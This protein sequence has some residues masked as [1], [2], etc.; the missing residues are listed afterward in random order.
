LKITFK[1]KIQNGLDTISGPV[2]DV[3]SEII[4]E[5]DSM[6]AYH[7]TPTVGAMLEARRYFA[8]DNVK[9][10][11]NRYSDSRFTGSPYYW[12]RYSRVSTPESYAGGTVVR[13]P[14]CN[15][16]APDGKYC[17]SEYITGSPTYISPFTHECQTNHIVLLTDGDPTADTAAANE[18]KAITGGGCV[19]Q[20]GGRGTCGEEIAS[21]LSTNDQHTFG[22]EQTITTHTIG[23]N[24]TT[25]WLKDVASEG[26]GGYYTAD[27][28]SQLSSALSN[29][30]DSVQDDGSSFV[31]PGATV[32]NFSKVSH[33][34][35]IY[36]ALFQPKSTPD[37]SGNLKRYDFSGNPASLHDKNDE[38]ALDSDTGNFKESSQ[39]FWSTTTDGNIVSRGGAAGRLTPSTR[40]AYTYTGTNT[41]LTH[42]SNEFSTDN[43]L[44]TQWY[45]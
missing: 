34:S 44:I 19:D 1:S 8:G 30:I 42:E 6:V 36:L 32:D 37:W 24:F 10:G 31:A 20:L 23:F 21:Y 11:L 41:D 5:I 28:A 13:S 3:R 39:S 15:I 12:G 14:N 18:V 38:P 4:A 25:Q 40:N 45:F 35:D 17:A 33:R 27:T 2:T 9:Y 43:D 26:G 16:N 29:I 22:G 7:G